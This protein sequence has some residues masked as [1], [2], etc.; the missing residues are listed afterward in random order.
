MQSAQHVPLPALPVRSDADNTAVRGVQVGSCRSV[1][2]LNDFTFVQGGASRVA[3]DEA[4]ALAGLGLDVI[5]IGAVGPVAAALAEAPLRTICLDQGQL[6]DAARHPGVAL[7]S[8]WNRRAQQAMDAALVGLDPAST[9]VHLH[10]Y[11]KALSTVPAARARQRGFSVLCT[12]H[13]FFTACPNGAFFDYVAAV[14]CKRVALSWDCATARCDKRRQVHKLFRVARGLVQRHVAGFPDNVLDYITLSRRSSEILRPYL[15]QGAR[16]HHVPHGMDL[17]R[18]PPVGV[19]AQTE[20]I[21][22]GRLETEKGVHLLAEAAAAVGLRV[23]F[24]GDGPLRAELEALAGV[25]VTGWLAPDQVFAELEHARCLVFPSLWYETYG[26]VVGEAAAR[27]VPAVVS[28]VSAPA[29]RVTDGLDGW[30]F[31]SGDAGALAAALRRTQDD[32]TVIAAGQAAYDGYWRQHASQAD[33]AAALV[34]IYDR[35]L[36]A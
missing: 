7:Q 21:C 23:R 34:A 13:D 15:P 17:E 26:L 36:S 24:V 9:L 25:S 27:G 8:M 1:I 16:F 12:L 30:V 5:F 11:T 35:I 31:R 4:V 14:P 33:H 19:G 22:I 3:I 28:D 29:E 6:L 18:R 20:L 2:V 10:G 32:E